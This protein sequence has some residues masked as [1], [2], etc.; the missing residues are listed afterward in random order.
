MSRQSGLA[1]QSALSN[2]GLAGLAGLAVLAEARWP[3]PGDAEPPGVPG[4]V[5]S[6]FNPLVAVVAERCLRRV[7]GEPPVPPEAGRALATVVVSA[8]GDAVSAR[9]VA[10]TVDA[11][12][13]VGPLFFFQSVPNSIAG[14]LAGRWG[15]AGPVVCLCPTGDPLADGLAQAGLLIGDGD[16]DSALVVLAE[17]EGSDGGAGRAAAVLVQG[18]ERAPRDT[19]SQG[20]RPAL[21]AQPQEI[22]GGPE[23]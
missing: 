4:F 1:S 17:Q 19:L 3:E 2:A 16:A 11:G 9:H 13:R 20:W 10:R 8:S 7:H 18:G 5:L 22:S 12:G 15:L 14:H 6:P 21:S 23:Q